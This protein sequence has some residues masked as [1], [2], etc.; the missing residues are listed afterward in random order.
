M[1][2]TIGTKSFTLPN[3]LYGRGY[4]VDAQE[5]AKSVGISK[6]HAEFILSRKRRPSPEVAVSLEKLTGIERR[7]WLWPDEF[8]N[9]LIAIASRQLL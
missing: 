6:K 9:D 3:I 8:Q 7:A 5:I 1:F 2:L 4:I